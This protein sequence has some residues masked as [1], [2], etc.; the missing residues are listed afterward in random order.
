MGKNNQQALL[1]EALRD[2]HHR[3]HVEDQNL[4]GQIKQIGSVSF[5]KRG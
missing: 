1:F 3:V 4:L 5:L 2:E